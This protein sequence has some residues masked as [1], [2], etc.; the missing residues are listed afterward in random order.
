MPDGMVVGQKGLMGEIEVDSFGR[1]QKQCE[2]WL[3]TEWFRDAN[4]RKY[5]SRG[6]KQADSKKRS[7]KADRTRERRRTQGAAEGHEDGHL[8]VIR[9]GQEDIVKVGYSKSLDERLRT[10]QTAH[11][12]T[13]AVVSSIETK[14]FHKND[15]PDKAIH[16]LLREE[17]HVRGE[18]WSLTEHTAG[19]LVE[20]GFDLGGIS[21]SLVGPSG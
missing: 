3:C 20:A 11:Y 9:P 10:L 15:P 14:R 17:D 16:M 8:Y 5:C 21:C 1:A 18:W 2:W 4:D 7:R 13:L 6:C 19:V 12:H